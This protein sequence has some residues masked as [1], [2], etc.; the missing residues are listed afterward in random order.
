M[1]LY[2]VLRDF[3]EV[4]IESVGYA[5][6]GARDIPLVCF[7]NGGPSAAKLFLPFRIAINFRFELLLFHPL[8]GYHLWVRTG[9]YRSAYRLDSVL[10]TKNLRLRFAC[11]FSAALCICFVGRK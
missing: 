11:L 5:I 10:Q 4:R 1:Q 7:L 9:L 6:L 2:D 3:I 8:L